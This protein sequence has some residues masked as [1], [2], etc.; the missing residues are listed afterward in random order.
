[1]PTHSHF[2]PPPV[3]PSIFHS[4]HTSSCSAP[5]FFLTL[6]RHP[7]LTSILPSALLLL[8]GA[9]I[10]HA[11][12]G[13]VLQIWLPCWSPGSPCFSYC[14][15]VKPPEKPWNVECGACSVLFSVMT[16]K[17][18]PLLV[19][20]VVF[21]SPSRWFYAGLK[22]CGSHWAEKQ[23]HSHAQTVWAALQSTSC[24]QPAG[25]LVIK[26]KV[27]DPLHRSGQRINSP[28]INVI[29]KKKK[30]KTKLSRL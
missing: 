30:E 22:L 2:N 6:P 19:T 15:L 4:F 17:N 23:E 9:A 1:M 18:F 28:K 8:L 5:T 14:E 27:T 24:W 16:R 3:S 13:F 26:Y 25:W 21:S 29:W 10:T 20:A 7:S 11:L 12:H